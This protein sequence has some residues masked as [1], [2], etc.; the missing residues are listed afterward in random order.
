MS[1]FKQCEEEMNSIKEK[2]KMLE[3]EN[4]ELRDE[5]ENANNALEDKE[6]E[7]KEAMHGSDFTPAQVW[8]LQMELDMAVRKAEHYLNLWEKEREKSNSLL[9]LYV[10][11][12]KEKQEI[13]RGWTRSE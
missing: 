6:Q 12:K 13:L 9:E 4:N 11:T 5:L 3:A 8:R 1:I 10:K 7:L 2:L